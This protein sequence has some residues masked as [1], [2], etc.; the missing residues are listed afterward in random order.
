M[1][2]ATVPFL[3]APFVQSVNAAADQDEALVFDQ[4]VVDCLGGDIF[5]FE[6]AVF[7]SVGNFSKVHWLA[8]FGQNHVDFVADVLW[9]DGRPFDKTPVVFEVSQL[10][11]GAGKGADLVGVF[12]VK[13]AR[14]VLR[15][16]VARRAF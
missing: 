2:S 9:V 3:I 5:S 13:L 14:E 10:F 8:V 16:A 15:F 6:V 12:V 4:F 1:I 11:A 7:D